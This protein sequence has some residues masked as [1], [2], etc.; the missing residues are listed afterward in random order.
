MEIQRRLFVFSVL[1]FCCPEDR[2]AIYMM[3]K[4]RRLKGGWF[5]IVAL[6]M[7]KNSRY[8]LS[9]PIKRSVSWE[10][11]ESSDCGV[12]TK[13]E[14]D[15]AIKRHF[16][17]HFFMARKL[18]FLWRVTCCSWCSIHPWVQ[19]FI[20]SSYSIC[21]AAIKLSLLTEVSRFF[22]RSLTNN[23][24][25]ST[26]YLM[27]A[28]RIMTRCPFSKDIKLKWSIITRVEIIA[29]NDGFSAESVNNWISS[30]NKSSDFY[31][32]NWRLN[33]LFAQWIRYAFAFQKNQ[34]LHDF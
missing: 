13:N 16:L 17:L 15:E 8:D 30:A 26:S 19:F 22:A 12:Y 14:N 2:E 4:R 9:N 27:D 23:W 29:A 5:F 28:G 18:W 7:S 24:H 32:F 34:F 6:F 20:A 21:F 3:I 31:L 10:N 11:N 1:L 25:L 33:A